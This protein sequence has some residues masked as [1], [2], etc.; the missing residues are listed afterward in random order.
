MSLS[1]AIDKSEII[2]I[3]VSEM[4]PELQKLIMSYTYDV[5][6][7]VN[8]DIY[9]FVKIDNSNTDKKLLKKF[10]TRSNV[11]T[12]IICSHAYKYLPEVKEAAQN[13]ILFAPLTLQHDFACYNTFL[14]KL[15]QDEFIIYGAHTQNIPLIVE[16]DDI[17]ISE[18]QETDS[19]EESILEEIPVVM[20][21]ETTKKENFEHN[22]QIT[23]EETIPQPSM[24]EV[25]Y[26]DI[27]IDEIPVETDTETDETEL[28]SV[29]ENVQIIN[30]VPPVQNILEEDSEEEP[31]IEISEPAEDEISENVYAQTLTEEQEDEEDNLQPQISLEEP[32]I[33]YSVEDIDIEENFGQPQIIEN[34]DYLVE[35]VAKDVDKVFYEKLP[36]ENMELEELETDAD[37]ELTED[38]LN[39]IDDLAVNENYEAAQEI[40]NF[41]EEEHVPV[42]PIY[43]A[44]DIEQKEDQQLEPGDRVTTPKY[45]EGVV[46][47]MIKYGNKMLCSIEFPNIGRPLLDPAM[48]EITKLS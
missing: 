39:L 20:E 33:D 8:S 28:V 37:D 1:I 12:T 43:A 15:N 13:V 18:E 45:G 36:D 3:D 48:T 24:P 38:D 9:S 41:E 2:V 27:V 19:K 5:M 30:E 42:V 17:E 21:E 6:Y 10:L 11:Y 47:K 35:Q 14:N 29:D 4:S 40:P 7:A 44:D 22:Q 31:E 26:P 23:I 46:E 25:E 16:L 34:K 32:E